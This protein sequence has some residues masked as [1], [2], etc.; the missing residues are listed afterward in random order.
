ML[1]K[2]FDILYKE[3]KVLF[4]LLLVFIVIYGCGFL[5]PDL[6]WS[7]HFIAFISPILQVPIFLG[8]LWLLFKMYRLDKSSFAKRDSFLINLKTIG[9][10]SILFMILTLVFTMVKD[11]Y[12]DAYKFNSY[13]TKTPSIIPKGTNE[14]FFTFKLTPWS[15]EG[16]ILAVITYIA[17]YLQVTYKTAFSIFDAF[18]GGLFVFTWLHFLTRFIKT[19]IWKIILG[20]AGI[21]AP[22][23]LIFFGHIEIYAP[24]VF[25]YLFW[26]YLSLLY[27]KTE[28]QKFLW[29]SLVLLV[30]CL[31]LHAISI[32]LIPALI[33]LFW[34]HFRGMYPNWKHVWSFI[35][36]PVF[37]LG[38]ILYFFVFNDH[39]DDRSLQKT[40]LAFD[41]IFLPL[42]SPEPPL[43]TYNLLGFN[44]FFDF[45]SI[46]LM[47]SPIALFLLVYFAIIKRKAI[48]WNAPE[49]II[50]GYC[51]LI[52][53]AFFFVINP[54]LSMPMDWDL[55]SLPAPFLLIFVATLTIQLEKE[56]SS[57]KILYA[58][59]ILA[60]LSLPVFIV[61]QS[62]KT[63]SKR[64]ESVAVHVYSTY[65]EWT[66]KI[67]DHAFSIG[68][69][70]INRLSRTDAFFEKLKPLAQEGIDYEY[71]ALLIDQGRYFLRARNSPKKALV[72]FDSA[73]YYAPANNAKLLS[74]EAYFLMNDYDKAFDVSKDLVQKQFPNPKKALKIFIHCSLE[75]VQY[76]EAFEASKV[77]LK[78]WPDD[79]TVKEVFQRL[80]AN[81]R[82]EELKFL[83]QNHNR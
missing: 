29:L 16:T 71:S 44:H 36:L 15:G 3:I 12:G 28:K 63:L 50:S 64:L 60:L 57:Y 81:D 38:G 20:L 24:I 83:F 70:K 78:N 22:F 77:Y 8:V 43:D 37:I 49:T 76:N 72:F 10:I 33:I 62:E 79:T 9:L 21:T 75:A 32:L 27:I 73:Q 40:A 11:F 53:T 39:I 17:Y 55:F 2:I 58:T 31:K 1:L 26:G 41:H 80:S 74:L 65:Y 4:T 7:T 18:F 68:E 42:F 13:L 61:H 69:H 46:L 25:M 45:L 51:L 47:W 6:W 19:N 34:K 30:I 82:T 48:N 14:K 59:K 5:F 56:V 66:A 23:V 52:Y 54:L 67:A 35:I